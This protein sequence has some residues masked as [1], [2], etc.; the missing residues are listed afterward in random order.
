[1]ADTTTTTYGLTKPEVGASE[2]T[3]GTKINDNFDNLDDLLDGTT[4]VTGIDI[5]SGTLDGVTIGGTTAGAGTFTNLTATG[6][7]TLAGA[8]TSADITFGDND[9]AIFGAGSDLQIY[10]D[11]SN[12][13]IHDDGTG[14]LQIQANNLRLTNQSTTRTYAEF[15]N[16]GSATLY[17]DNALK[18]A[19][20][21]TGVDITGTLTSDGLTV[22]GN[23]DVSGHVDVGNAYSLR[24]GDGNER[25]T[26]NNTGL[27]DA[28]TNNA[29]RLSINAS[30]DISFYEDTGTT[31]KF[32]WDASAESLGIGTSSPQENLHIAAT[33]PVFR[34][35]GGSRSYQQFV[36]GTD[37]VIRDVTA[38][39]NRIT[40]DSSGNVGIGTSSPAEELDI[41]AN[42]AT[43]RLD[44][45][46]NSKF[47]NPTLQFLTNAGNIDYINFGDI[48]DADVGQIAYAHAADY[49]TFRTAASERMRIDS[50]GNV[51]IGETSPV[52]QLHVSG[53]IAVS[54]DNTL[55]QVSRLYEASG[56]QIDSGDAQN[57]TRPIVFRTGGSERMRIDSSGD[58]LIG[59]SAV[60]STAA[61]TQIESFGLVRIIRNGGDALALHRQNSDGR[62]MEF[63]RDTTKVGVFNVVGGDLA[64]GTGVAGLRFVD[65]SNAIV[66]WNMT[67]NSSS[68]NSIDLGKASEKFR[69]IYVEAGSGAA[70]KGY[71]P[72][73]WINING[74]VPSVRGSGNVSS[75][76]EP[77]AGKYYV[78]FATTFSDTNYVATTGFQRNLTSGDFVQVGF[79][80]GGGYDYVEFFSGGALADCSNLQVVWLR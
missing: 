15:I 12:S 55:T 76:T 30:G 58:V 79:A 3:W 8:S 73:A 57:N 67:G 26:G 78:T 2:D 54:S 19:T 66:P 38:T 53:G 21:S 41:N 77:Q 25:I 44:A 24:W 75:M 10:H 11:G 14:D 65:G 4:P 49:M 1:M 64:V 60:N 37:F 52:M 9:K 20:T 34:L 61:G 48:D 35:E 69:H 32:F 27:L 43:V 33:T 5:N 40:L 23:A 72:R 74:S 17:H 28:Y 39:A 31:A 46:S 18:L 22:D 36:S 13:I 56:L 68:N 16:A 59:K 63:N 45:A 29:K 51:G 7:T 6:T 42:N 80:R 47:G 71:L 62:I 50:S 70:Q